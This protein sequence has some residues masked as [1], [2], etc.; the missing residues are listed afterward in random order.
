M[1][2]GMRFVE[3]HRQINKVLEK[4]YSKRELDQWY[5]DTSRKK[6]ELPREIY[7]IVQVS[8]V[9]VQDGFCPSAHVYLKLKDRLGEGGFVLLQEI[10]L[11]IS[12]LVPVYE[13]LLFHE[14]KHNALVGNLGLVG[15]ANTFELIEA[16]VQVNKILQ[17][18]G[19]IQLSHEYDLYDTVYEW[20]QL[21]GIDPV[22]RRL[23]LKDAAFVDILELCND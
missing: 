13:Y 5:V 7:D 18:H 4:L 20:G 15:P 12:K 6:L 22:N 19:Y 10:Q 23:T 9:K 3:E 17:Q 1:S 8:E 16:E 11:T 2:H 21:E 14:V